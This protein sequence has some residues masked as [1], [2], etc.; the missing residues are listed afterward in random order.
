MALFMSLFMKCFLINNDFSKMPIAQKLLEE[1][2]QKELEAEHLSVED[3]SD[4]CGYK[5]HVLVVS[6]KFEGLSLIQRQRLVNEILKDEMKEIHALTQKT[7]T[8]E[9][10]KKM[11]QE[12]K[13]HAEHEEEKSGACIKN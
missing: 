4:G 10:W 7:L 8:P 6:K 3:F 5:F 1:K 11:S 13:D 12:T 2:I 9:Q